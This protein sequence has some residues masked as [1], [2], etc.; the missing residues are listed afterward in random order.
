MRVHNFRELNVW[1]K[2]IE[3]SKRIYQF[4]S[5]FPTEE[6]YGLKSQIQ[7]SAIAIPSNI[8]EGCGRN[9]PKDTLQ[10]LYIARGSAYELETQIYLSADFEYINEKQQGQLLRNVEELKKLLNGFINYYKTLK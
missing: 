6:K 4:T 3:L 2:G 9:S 7:R 10:F 1:Q 8:A 5:T